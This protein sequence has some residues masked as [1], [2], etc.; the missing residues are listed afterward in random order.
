M[1]ESLRRGVVVTTA[2]RRRAS[3]IVFSLFYVARGGDTFAMMTKILDDES[4]SLRHRG[5]R[6]CK[7]RFDGT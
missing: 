2:S 1:L 7:R 5:L 4:D 3:D 6:D